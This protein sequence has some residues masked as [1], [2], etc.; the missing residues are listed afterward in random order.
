MRARLKRELDRLAFYNDK[1]IDYL[2]HRP[3]QV[4]AERAKR[5]A[6]IAGLAAEIGHDTLPS[7]FVAALGSDDLAT[8]LTGKYLDL[9]KLHWR[10]GRA[11]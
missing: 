3:D 10:K 7:S 4:E 6:A 2:R 5:L 11:R 9:V 1:G 8:D